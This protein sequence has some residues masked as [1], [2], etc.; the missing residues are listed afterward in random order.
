MDSTSIFTKC[1]VMDIG[2]GFTKAGFSTDEAPKVFFETVI[3]KPIQSKQGSTASKQIVVGQQTNSHSLYKLEQP[4]KRGVVQSIALLKPVVNKVLDDLRLKSLSDTPVVITEATG[5]PLNSRRQLLEM[6]FEDC[7]ANS[8]Y[9]G[10]QAVLGLYGLGKTTG[11]VLDIGSGLTQVGCIFDGYK[12]DHTFERGE[13]G[14]IDVQGYLAML[15]RKNGL[16]LKPQN[17]TALLKRIKETKCKLVDHSKQEMLQLTE[18]GGAIEEDATVILPDGEEIKIG[19]ERLLAPEILFKPDM[20]GLYSKGV[21][22]LLANSIEKVDIDLRSQLYKSICLIGGTSSLNN[23]A[24]RMSQELKNIIPVNARVQVVTS[25][26]RN[27]WHSWKGASIIAQSSQISNLWIKKSDYA[28]I[29]AD[30]LA[31]RNF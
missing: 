16:Y 24:N 25:A 4:L 29:G 15:L 18:I 20:I 26:G 3:G 21:H 1:V 13:V 9:F 23:F 17:E 22:H 7:E 31:I 14:G 30:A 28:E 6:Y 11:C 8:L 19:N 2:S 5:T 10:N 12:L 27:D